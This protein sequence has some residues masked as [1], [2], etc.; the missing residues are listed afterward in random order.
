MHRDPTK[1]WDGKALHAD[2]TKARATGGTRADR[3]LCDTCNK[4]RGTGDRDHL[5]PALTGEW[6]PTPAS[7]VVNP[8]DP[9]GLP[10][11]V[12]PLI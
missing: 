12:A 7:R 6:P 8:D 10:A 2:H 11:A 4:Q 1:N 9:H 5:R 3:L